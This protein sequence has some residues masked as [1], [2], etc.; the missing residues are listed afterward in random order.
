MRNLVRL[1]LAAILAAS[2]MVAGAM[3]QEFP[4]KGKPITIMV[5]FSAGGVT[6]T[7]ARMMAA[8]FEKELGTPVQVVNKPGANSQVGLS[9]LVRAKPDGYTLS[10]ATL[11]T[12]TTHYLDPT[13]GA[14]YTRK[15]FQPIGM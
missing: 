8:E 12:V 9:E 6:D 11:P 14:V 2:G 7:S 13:R 3:A 1:S 4:V 10:Y 15:D 5:P